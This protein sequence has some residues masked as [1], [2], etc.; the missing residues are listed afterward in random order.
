MCCTLDSP[1]REFNAYLSILCCYVSDFTGLDP[2]TNDGMVLYY[3]LM[4]EVDWFR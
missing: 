2:A 3:C 1:S 4:T